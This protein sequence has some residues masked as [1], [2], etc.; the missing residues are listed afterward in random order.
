LY[1][2]RKAAQLARGTTQGATALDVARGFGNAEGVKRP[3]FRPTVQSVFNPRGFSRYHSVSSVTGAPGMAGASYGLAGI[4]NT[5]MGRTSMAQNAVLNSR[6]YDKAM[7]QGAVRRMLAAEGK[8]AD[9]IARSV[10]FFTGQDNSVAFSGGLL[11]Y[12]RAGAKMDA[13]EGKRA[14]RLAQRK[15]NH[16]TG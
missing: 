1:R 10:S 13:L 9:D 4:A 5:V 6:V 12:M 3:V 14:R 8:S 15:I 11:G 2:R 16:Q 7:R